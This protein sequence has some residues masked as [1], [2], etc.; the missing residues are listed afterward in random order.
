MIS[1]KSGESFGDRLS[2][3]GITMPARYGR[4]LIL[5]FGIRPYAAKTPN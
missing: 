4:P 3:D 1:E 5:L 2:G